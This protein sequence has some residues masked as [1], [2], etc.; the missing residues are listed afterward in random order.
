MTVAATARFRL[1]RGVRLKTTDCGAQML[2]VP[3][4]VVTLNETAA[5]TLALVDGARD[6]DQIATELA[7]AYEAEP[8]HLL[9][10]VRA[11]LDAFVERGFVLVNS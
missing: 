8:A 4:G 3:E 2:L 6:A 7:L 11:V 5:D 9:D 10:D 1:A